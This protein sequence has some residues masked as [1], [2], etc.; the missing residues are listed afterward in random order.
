MNKILEQLEFHFQ[1]GTCSWEMQEIADKAGEYAHMLRWLEQ[2]DENAE[3]DDY[4][5][6]EHD[7]DIIPLFQD[8]A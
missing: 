6:E 8:R 2:D 5:F 3:L 4:D 1:N 7:T